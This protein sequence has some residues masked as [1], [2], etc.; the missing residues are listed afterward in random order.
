[1]YI[2][3]E[4]LVFSPSLPETWTV[5]LLVPSQ[6]LEQDTARKCSSFKSHIRGVDQRVGAV[7]YRTLL[8]L[9]LSL[10]CATFSW[11]RHITPINSAGNA[12]RDSPRDVIARTRPPEDEINSLLANH[13]ALESYSR[14]PDCFRRVAGNIRQRCGE[15][16]MDED[17][18]VKAAISMTLC[19]I[20][21]ATHHSL[22]LECIS[23]TVDS[24][25][26]P[27]QIQGECVDALS[28]SAQFWSS[29]SGYLR[30]VHTA[31]EIYKNSSLE[32]MALIRSILAREKADMAERKHWNMQVSELEDVSRGLKAMFKQMDVAMN[33][34]LAT[35]LTKVGYFHSGYR[36]RPDGHFQIVETIKVALTD[37][38]LNARLDDSRIIDT[39][40]QSISQRHAQS[41][42]EILQFIQVSFAN[43]LNIALSPFRAETLHVLDLAN[44]A[45]ERWI[46]LTFQFSVLQQKI[47]EVSEGVTDTAMTLEASS[48]QAY[49]LHEEQIIASS[50]ASHLADTLTL[51]TAT[52]QDSLDKFNASAALLTQNLLPRNG[53]TQILQLIERFIHEHAA[54]GAITAQVYARAIS[55]SRVYERL[56]QQH[57]MSH[58]SAANHPNSSKPNTAGR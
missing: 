4:Y 21:T 55:G 25:S 39:E 38:Q 7:A 2:V 16:E 40:L 41:L 1:M 30:E 22:P 12:V 45:N 42:N 19:E 17:E 23:F 43:E 49:A 8:I 51:L 32:T 34:K 48:K 58:G 47:M 52:T 31:K 20:A 56:V 46:N 24:D 33:S 5:G 3:P 57:I 27:I 14:H 9:R 13:A 18:R 11:P 15:Q 6:R 50:S 10:C 36:K 29:Y 53:L 54:T 44:T 35:G 28:R 26:P 37:V